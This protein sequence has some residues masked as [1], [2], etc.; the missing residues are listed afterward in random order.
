ME[1]KHVIFLSRWMKNIPGS[2]RPP[3]RRLFQEKPPRTTSE[4]PGPTL[5]RAKRFENPSALS[6]LGE[7]KGSM[8]ILIAC[9]ETQS[10]DQNVSLKMHAPPYTRPK[11][12]HARI[13]TVSGMLFASIKK[14]HQYTPMKNEKEACSA[15]STD[16]QFQNKPR[17]HLRVGDARAPPPMSIKK[18]ACHQ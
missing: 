3:C 10:V 9:A 15:A 6:F 13:V 5:E 7:N 2:V 8:N 17:P 1:K 4:T 11:T 12:E 18:T 16:E 14:K